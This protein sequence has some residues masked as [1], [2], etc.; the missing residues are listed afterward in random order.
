MFRFITII[1]ITGLFNS[2]VEN[3]TIVYL[4]QCEEKRSIENNIFCSTNLANLKEQLPAKDSINYIGSDNNYHYLKY[5]YR[6]AFYSYDKVKR[7]AVMSFKIPLN[8]LMLKTHIIFQE[9]NTWNDG[10]KISVS[11]L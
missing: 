6:T 4:K 5:H 2:C 10:Y 1:V 7:W 11:D 8:E 3:K 9:S